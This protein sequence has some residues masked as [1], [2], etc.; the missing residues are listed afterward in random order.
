MSRSIENDEG[1][2]GHLKRWKPVGSGRKRHVP[3]LK[4][5]TLSLT[6]EQASLLRKWGRGDMS[7]GLRWLIT[8]AAPFIYRAEKS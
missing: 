6:D 2:E 7:A 4:R 3:P 8:V 5:R 1:Y